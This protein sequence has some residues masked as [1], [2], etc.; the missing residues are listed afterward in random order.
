MYERIASMDKRNEETRPVILL[1]D[2]DPLNR[3]IVKDMLENCG[4][5]CTS[6]ERP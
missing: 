1:V 2:N 4:C 3:E 5:R 6:R